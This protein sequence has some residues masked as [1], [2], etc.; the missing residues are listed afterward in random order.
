M[1]INTIS[2]GV[3]QQI[4]SYLAHHK[5]LNVELDKPLH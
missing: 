2:I 5:S 4:T 3:K 1:I